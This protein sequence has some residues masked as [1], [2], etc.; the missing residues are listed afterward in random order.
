MNLTPF[1]A[2]RILHDD[3]K[4]KKVSR[5][6]VRIATAGVTLG[7]A[8][9][10]LS[11][12]IVLGFK[13]E[14]KN[15]VIGFGSHI[16]V[17]DYSSFETHTTHNL[18]IPNTLID[19]LST[20][21]NV[22][23]IQRFCDKQGI[24]KTNNDFHGIVLRGV[25]HEFDPTFL[26]T[27][28]CQGQLP[29]FADTTQSGQ[30]VVSRTLADKLTL[31]V[32]SKVYAY[33][34]ENTV[35]MRRLTV[36]AIYSTHLSEFDNTLVYTDLLTTQKLHAAGPGHYTG[37]EI[38]VHNLAQVRQTA[39]DIATRV[40]THPGTAQNPPATLTIHELYPSI[41]A[42]LDLLDLNVWV[43][44]A[45]MTAVAGFT[46]ISGLLIII[47]ERTDFIGIMKSLGA[48][49]KTL[50][51]IFLYVAGATALRGLL[52]G[53]IIGIGLALLQHRFHLFP[54]DASTYYVDFVPVQMHFGY[55]ALIDLA[56]L[57]CS[58]AALLVPSM[59]VS[60]ISPARSVNIE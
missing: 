39:D 30:I 3:R 11:L 8:V 13:Q 4:Q 27:N 60:R 57:L 1:I 16:Q 46:M 19:T 17:I 50:S 31:T 20:L 44:L 23:H 32:G 38:T 26:Q 43:I 53:N 25:G 18:P 28:L 49:N 51:R 47:L 52:W 6:A 14:I 33:F 10:I 45:L 35:R 54:L 34:F 55:I 29:T 21:P 40:R 48:T 9:I 24:L 37:L 22:A 36:A 2:R 58:M 56:T 59:L 41:F 5:P 12:C 7:T 42:W 15:K